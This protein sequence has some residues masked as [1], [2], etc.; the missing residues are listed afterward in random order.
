MKVRYSNYLL[1]NWIFS[2]QWHY[3]DVYP[4]HWVTMGF[5]FVKIQVYIQE[6]KWKSWLIVQNPVQSTKCNQGL[7]YMSLKA[8]VQIWTLDFKKQLQSQ[9]ISIP[10]LGWILWLKLG[11]MLGCSWDTQCIKWQICWTYSFN[12]IWLNT[13]KILK[14]R[15][16]KFARNIFDQ[17]NIEISF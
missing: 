11:D 6:T 13:M 1:Q 10:I 2:I 16:K 4:L 15:S 14:T 3:L 8:T 12:G 9:L 7:L 5:Q 17:Q